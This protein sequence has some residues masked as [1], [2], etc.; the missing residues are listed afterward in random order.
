[1]QAQR[2][3]FGVLAIWND[4]RVG[5][6]SEFEHWYQSEH[7]LERL[8]V[9]G[10]LLGR[11]YEAVAGTPRYFACYLT[12]SPETLT[13]APYLARLNDPT[14]MTQRVMKEMFIDMTRALCRL[15]ER[16]GHCRGAFAVTARFG[17]APDGAA[18]SAAAAALAHDDAVACTELWTALAPHEVPVTS[19]ESLR[20]R[21]RRIS[22]CLTA[23]TLR[24]NDGERIAAALSVQ[25]P[26]S[27]V[28]LYR[29]LCGIERSS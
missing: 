15:S 10:F 27:E 28:G 11:R 12:Q 8:A 7:L 3:G 14:P 1:M 17:E 13:S 25:F 29:L 23:E 9:P 6:E 21:D 20:G 16:R 5:R 18:L 4:C 26:T 2:D 19:E 24:Q 22:A